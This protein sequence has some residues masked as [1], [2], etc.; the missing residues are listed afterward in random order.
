MNFVKGDLFELAES[1]VFDVVVHGCNCFNTMGS[2]IA[3][4]VR[5]VYPDAYAED[6][7]TVRGD[8]KKVGT[9]TSA[10]VGNNSKFVIVNAYTQYRYN[11]S[12]ERVDLFE[13]AGFESILNSLLLTFPG[14]RFGFPMIGMDRA[15]GDKARILSLIQKFSDAIHSTGGTATMVEYTGVKNK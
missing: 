10:L 6:C 14:K 5:T 9:Y 4:T 11:P 15:G 2:G 3:N 13:Y 12:S 7:K 8:H 1:G